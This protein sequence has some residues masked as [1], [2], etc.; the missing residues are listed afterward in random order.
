MKVGM[1]AIGSND[2]K[3]FSRRC[4]SATGGARR[5]SPGCPGELIGGRDLIA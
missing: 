1:V 2:F 5:G 4:G 3:V